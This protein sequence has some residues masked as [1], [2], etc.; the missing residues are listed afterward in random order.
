MHKNF[1]AVGMVLAISL[2][3]PSAAQ[4][5]AWIGQMAGEMAAQQQQAELEAACRKGAPADPDDVK[6]SNRRAEKLM[7]AYFDLTSKSSL[8]DIQRVFAMGK[9]DVSWKDANGKVP[10]DQLGARLD[11][12]ST[13]RTLVLS[14]VGGDNKTMRAI[15]SVGDGADKIY[16]AADI[17]VGNWISSSAIWHMTVSKTL[18]DTPPAYCHFD[19]EQSF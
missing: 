12:V 11:E 14:V 5:Q 4:S 9:P 10:I 2:A 6:S 15:W 13:K 1:Q 19:S 18:P 16:Y 17:V 7:D 8:R 3:I